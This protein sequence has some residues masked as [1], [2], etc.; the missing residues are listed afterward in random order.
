MAVDHAGRSLNGGLSTELKALV[1][2]AKRLGKLELELAKTELSGKVGSLGAGAGLLVGAG[3]CGFI[4]L[5]V[6][7]AAGVL[8]LAT[9]VAGWLAALI[10]FAVYIVLAAVMGLLGLAKLKAATPIVPERTIESLKGDL[11]W[12]GTQ[13]KSPRR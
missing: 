5:C 6:I 10:V 2:Q 13:L 8:A 9:A 1:G 11:T 12:V 4:A 7:T 3:L